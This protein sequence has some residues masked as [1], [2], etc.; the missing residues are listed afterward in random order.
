M[1]ATAILPIAPVLSRFISSENNNPKAIS[2]QVF[3][4]KYKDR[5]DAFKYEWVEGRVEK[6]S[7]CME[8]MQFFIK[9][10]LVN[11]ADSLNLNG[12]LI[13]NPS[14]FFLENHRRPD[15]A[16]LTIDQIYNLADPEAYEVPDFV[17]EIISKNDQ[18]NAIKGKMVNY[19]DAGVKV[20]WH[21]FPNYQQVDVY[22]GPNL[23]VMTVCSGD[24][25][26]S[27][28]P[29]LPLFELPASAIFRK[30]AK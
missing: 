2:W 21:I 9:L 8:R 15:I 7:R 3:E 28:A 29:A 25:I 24:K 12:R 10:N 13:I 17:I 27:A 26:C 30:P 22:S 18:L 6:S 4:R 11:F 19:R 1:P 20:V 5:I 16:W 14:L 23:E